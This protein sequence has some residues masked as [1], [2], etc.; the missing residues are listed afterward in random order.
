MTGHNKIEKKLIEYER[1]LHFS[2][3][4]K[5]APPPKER[6]GARVEI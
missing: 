6:K 4:D 2:L 5:W 1:R 3:V